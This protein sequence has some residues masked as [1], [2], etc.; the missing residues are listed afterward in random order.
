MAVEG[1]VG[2]GH[3]LKGEEEEEE[4]E[5]EAL[6]CITNGA[7]LF[8]VDFTWIRAV[9]LVW[10]GNFHMIRRF[11]SMLMTVMLPVEVR[12]LWSANRDFI[13]LDLWHQIKVFYS[14]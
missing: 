14:L 9:S 7:L 3:R 10:V 2:G 6:F 4:E 5:E 1:W 12:H 11:I 13:G 8:R